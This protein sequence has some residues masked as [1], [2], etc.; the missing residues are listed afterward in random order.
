MGLTWRDAVATLFVAAAAAAYGLWVTGTAMPDAS[1]R[2]IGAVVLGLGWAGCMADRDAMAVVYGVDRSR[3]R[4]PMV[5]VA[6]A[7][8]LGAV[9]LVAGIWAL[10]DASRAMVAPLLA[11]MVLLWA[12]STA[13]HWL[14]GGAQRRA[15]LGAGSRGVATRP[16]AGT[17]LRA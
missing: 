7:S 14:A 10:L 11:A 1:T 13:R 12:M 4:P 17:S 3:R 2:V 9:A 6:M 15:E 5:Y 8:A 16:P